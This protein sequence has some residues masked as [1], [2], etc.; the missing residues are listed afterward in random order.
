VSGTP[1]AAPAGREREHLLELLSRPTADAARALLGCLL[2]RRLGDRLLAAR[3][4]ETEA[5]LGSEDP[6]A[7]AFAGRTARTEPLWGSPGTIYVYLVYGMHHCLN[8]AVDRQ[9]VPGCALI[10]AAEPLG[11]CGLS[12]RAL[13]GP[14]RLC[15]GLGIAAPLSGRHLF[16]PRWELTLRSGPPPREVVVGCRVGI[17]RA[18]ERPLRFADAESPAVSLPLPAGVSFAAA[19]R[20]TTPHSRHTRVPAPKRGRP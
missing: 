11:D 10:R 2:L 5:Y 4:V 3:I 15:R 16:E 9:G 14:G 12:G 18:A 6:A 17:T 1:L 13:S 19:P 8:L 7:H 20:R